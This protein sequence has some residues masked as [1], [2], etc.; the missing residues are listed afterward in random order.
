MGSIMYKEIQFTNCKLDH[1]LNDLRQ[2]GAVIIEY[3]S[4]TVLVSITNFDKFIIKYKET[5][6]YKVSSLNPE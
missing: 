5:K 1:I 4:S 6:T 2:S 3:D